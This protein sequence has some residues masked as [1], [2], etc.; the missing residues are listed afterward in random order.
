MASVF[1]VKK[2][3]FLFLYMM[4][5]QKLELYTVVLLKGLPTRDAD[6]NRY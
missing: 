5:S 1:T 3:I 4:F 2:K 6:F